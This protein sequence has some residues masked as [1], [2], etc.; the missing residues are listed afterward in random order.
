[1]KTKFLLIFFTVF[2]ITVPNKSLLAS[3]NTFNTKEKLRCINDPEDPTQ[4]GWGGQFVCKANTSHFVDGPGKG[5]ISRWRNDF[6]K[7]FKEHADRC[8]K[9]KSKASY[10]KPRIINTTDLGAD[11]DDEQ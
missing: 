3:G 11:P 9:P 7:E 1:M 6:Q 4:P 2:Y 8:I 10:T 5:S